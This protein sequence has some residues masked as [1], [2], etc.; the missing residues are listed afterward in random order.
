MSTK[1]KDMDP[2]ELRN[3]LDQIVK[4]GYKKLNRQGLPDNLKEMV[5]TLKADLL[6][7]MPGVTIDT[8]DEAVTYEVLHD[9]NL[10]KK[11]SNY[12]AVYCFQAVGKHYTKPTEVRD[13]DKPDLAYWKSYLRFLDGKGLGNSTQADECRWWIDHITKGDDEGE[14]IRLLDIC[15]DW[16]R[17]SDDQQRT[18]TVQTKD[19]IVIELP[20]FNA[21]REFAYLVMR[22]QLTEESLA[23]FFDDAIT[24]VNTERM[25]SRH[26]RLTREEARKDPDV[27]ARQKRL[28]VIDWLRACNTSGKK[29]S[30]ALTPLIDEMQYQQLRKTV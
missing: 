13:F 22:R 14:T 30:T 11:P 19:G 18:F 24:E 4:Q 10:T 12:S 7:Y 23:H 3:R 9:E 8:I 5:D 17:K 26:H 27:I 1:I 29:P 15:A 21:R 6:R 25:A 28:A 2:F 16:V 20:A